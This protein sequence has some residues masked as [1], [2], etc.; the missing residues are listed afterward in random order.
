MS[1]WRDAAGDMLLGSCCAGCA[2]PGRRLC[3]ACSAALVASPRPAWPDPVPEAL[4]HPTTVLPYAGA[5]Y[6]GR[7]QQLIVAYKDAARFGLARPLGRVLADVVAA[8]LAVLD[9]SERVVL[10]PVPS[11]PA[12]VRRR[13]HDH[14][15]RV[16][17][18]GA[19]VLRR[20][21]CD[22]GVATMLRQRPGVADSV[23]LSAQQRAANL[24]GAMRVRAPGAG[25]GATVV[26]V[27]DVVTTGASVAEAT[28]ALR[29]AGISPSGVATVA[30]T[31]RRW[32]TRTG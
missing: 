14:V 7:M 10:V 8:L 21:G 32:P 11:S 1:T 20:R 22:A 2:E 29:R 24:T 4:L 28:V 12:A 6:A 27:D 16:A 3:L 19:Q 9:A 15:P 23:G 25:S 5:P 13:G 31:Q 18:V 30:C 17:R 26:I